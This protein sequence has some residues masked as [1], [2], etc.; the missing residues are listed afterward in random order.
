MSFSKISRMAAGTR[1]TLG[2]VV[3]VNDVAIGSVSGTT[4]IASDTPDPNSANNR[5]TVSIE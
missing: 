2:V 3:E 4:N 1:A 5:S